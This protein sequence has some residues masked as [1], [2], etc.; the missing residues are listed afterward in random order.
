VPAFSLHKKKRLHLKNEIRTLLHEG[1]RWHCELF[2]IVYRSV[3]ERNFSRIAVLVSKRHGN[4]VQRNRIKRVYRE[5]FRT[6][7]EQL[8]MAYDILLKPK[9]A[10]AHAYSEILHNYLY[11]IDNKL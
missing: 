1:K 3:P 6:N 5:V 7:Q 2:S 4:A 10:R 9:W 11:W 8:C